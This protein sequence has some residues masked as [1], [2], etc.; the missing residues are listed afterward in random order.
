MARSYDFAVVKI[1]PDPIRD[2]ALNCAV[3]V[4]RPEKLDVCLTPNPERLRTIAPALRDDGLDELS[5]S[6]QSLD[7]PH[8]STGE[9]IERLR[10]LPGICVS[11]PEC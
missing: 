5:I 2:E 7:A 1:A 9:R 4:L 6:L 11:A 3:V 10:R 8:L